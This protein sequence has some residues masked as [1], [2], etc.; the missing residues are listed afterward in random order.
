V[1]EATGICARF[2]VEQAS[3]SSMVWSQSQFNQRAGVGVTWTAIV[4]G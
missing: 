4:I 3:L 2:P 1:V